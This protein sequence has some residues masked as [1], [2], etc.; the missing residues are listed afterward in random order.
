MTPVII[1]V[2]ITR[3]IPSTRKT[4]KYLNKLGKLIVLVVFLDS[5]KVTRKILDKLFTSDS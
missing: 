1:T 2:K 5:R 3:N 4:P